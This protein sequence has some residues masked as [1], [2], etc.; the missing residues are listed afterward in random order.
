MVPV[1]GLVAPKDADRRQAASAIAS[2][3]RAACRASSRRVGQLPHEKRIV[4]G[5]NH[6]SQQE[7]AFEFALPIPVEP[8]GKISDFQTH[9][10]CALAAAF[11]ERP[12]SRWIFWSSVMIARKS[13]LLPT[14]TSGTTSA[15]KCVKLRAASKTISA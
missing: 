13:F 5:A 8:P 9:K 11:K 10:D 7:R 3:Q 2:A 15:P 12:V 1:E 6:P 4:C 14:G